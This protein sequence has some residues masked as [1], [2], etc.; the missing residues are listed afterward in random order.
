ML[1]LHWPFGH[2]LGEPGNVL[3]QRTILH[4]LLSL[5]QTAPVPGLVVD[6]P[7]RWKRGV[8]SEVSDWTRVSD[9][10]A[11]GLREAIECVDKP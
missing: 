10:C 1:Y 8:Y 6:L 4:D 3:Q 9:A 11:K 7:Y 2:A 5:A